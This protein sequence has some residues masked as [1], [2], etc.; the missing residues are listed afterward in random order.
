MNDTSR[1]NPDAESVRLDKWLWAARFFKT[2]SL[3]TT[4]IKGGHVELDGHRAKASVTI[5]PGQR[6][7]IVKAEQVFEID[8]IDTASKRGPASQAQALYVETPDS[9]TRREQAAAERRAANLAMPRP[10]ARPDRKSR[11]RL[12]RFKQGD[13]AG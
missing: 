5:R 2:R 12:R 4:A 7:R 11:R 9:V 13:D 10:T 3:A 1:N 6:L 8:V